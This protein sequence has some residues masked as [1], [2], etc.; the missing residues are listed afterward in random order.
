MFNPAAPLR[1]AL[2]LRDARLLLTGLAASEA[3]DWLY[4]LALLALV[5]DRTG[6]STWL[7]VATAAR[8][9][10]LVA[11]GPLGGVLADRCD[12]RRLMIGSDL[13]R[14]ACMAALAVV[15]VSGAPIVLAPALAALT[16]AAGAAYPSCVVALVP[17]LVADD[18]LPAVNA[19]RVSITHLCVIAGP[20]LGAALL[21]LGSAFAAFAVNGATFLAGAA[22][23]AALPREALRRPVAAPGPRAGLRDELLGGWQALRAYPDACAL[24][25]A[26]VAASAVYGA[27]TVLL[28][29]VSD[30]LGLGTAGYGYLLA[31]IGAGGVLAAGVAD[32]AAGSER[33]RFV[34]AL[35]VLAIGA[36]LPVVAVAGWLPG[37]VVLVAIVGAASLV[38]E[39]VADTA[40]QRS[41]DPAVFARAY[42]LVLPAALA[43][44]AAGALLAPP[45]VSLFGLDG[46][47]VL[48]GTLAA[49][50][51][52][53][54]LAAPSREPHAALVSG[55]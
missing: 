6:S 42:G 52:G 3:G 13:L 30:R 55:A 26:E 38:T 14:C 15:A 48:T 10:P 29:L 45:C 36:P 1:A 23:V 35:G 47:L 5:Y 51:G 32:H 4:N 12:R 22:V 19:A 8:M 39:V 16:T 24:V 21:L 41:L 31:A 53:A 11:L 9:L 18:D 43:G 25:C 33:P 44:I 37:V 49:A 20:V 34:L 17:R 54:M 40:L 2:R 46:A 28:V 50:C 27:L 7:G